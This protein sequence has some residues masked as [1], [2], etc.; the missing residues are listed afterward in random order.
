MI[1][2]RWSYFGYYFKYT[3]LNAFLSEYQSYFDRKVKTVYIYIDLQNCLKTQF[4]DDAIQDMYKSVKFKEKFSPI[5]MDTFLYMARTRQYFKSIGINTKFI[6]YWDEGKTI[7]HTALLPSY[8][9]ARHSKSSV[10]PEIVLRTGLDSFKVQKRILTEITYNLYD[11]YALKLDNLESDFVPHFILK[12][13]KDLIDDKSNLHFLISAD[14][15]LYQTTFLGDNIFQ[16][17]RSGKNDFFVSKKSSLSSL[18]KKN[19]N[20]YSQ[21]VDLWRFLFSIAGDPGD[22]VPSIIP[23]TGYITAYNMAKALKDIGINVE[24]VLTDV[25]SNEQIKIP[26][27]KINNTTIRKKISKIV[28]DENI[29]SR[30]R[31]NILLVL[32]DESYKFFK[33]EIKHD[34]I[35]ITRSFKDEVIQKTKTIFDKNDTIEYNKLNNIMKKIHLIENL[36]PICQNLCGG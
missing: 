16:Y 24:N 22:E 18:L 6:I 26:V 3:H 15:D 5:V 8:K 9:Q 34:K 12:E 27:S 20:D 10:L 19:D 21:D 31:E 2:T 33:Q 28:S 25:V 1:N 4:Y 11:C 23:R 14:K 30:W 7:Y 13:N 32:F 35:K 29:I 17:V 36:D